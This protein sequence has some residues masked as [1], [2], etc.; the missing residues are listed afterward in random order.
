[1]KAF[2]KISV[3]IPVYNTEEHLHR[4][5][6][7][8]LGQTYSNLE[9]LL[10]NDGSTDNSGSIC[11]EYAQNDARVKVIHQ[12]NKGQS[13]ARNVGVKN[14]TG[15]YIIYVDSDDWIDLEMYTTMMDVMIANNQEIVECG[16]VHRYEDTET[17]PPNAG[18]M[19]IE[20]Q[21][22]ALKRI[23]A[24][25]AFSVCRRLCH[26][27]IITQIEFL[28]ATFAEDVYYTVET[29]SRVKSIAVM[30]YPFYN[31]YKANESTTRGAY[32][33]RSLGTVDAALFV[34]A[35]VREITSDKSFKPII[36]KFIL[37]ILM[38]NYKSMQLYPAVDPKLTHRK[39]IKKMINKYLDSGNLNFKLLLAA[40]LP[41]R[42]YNF[43]SLSNKLLMHG[44]SL[45]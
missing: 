7:S 9:I 6:D 42:F 29:I 16:E 5:I 18:E 37:T 43:L 31:Y 41:I 28:E 15:Q 3:I 40:I 45:L 34:D 22:T 38:F 2:E 14:A 13:V 35:K 8:I 21:L 4:C 33:L 24:N 10:I 39:R 11:D 12:G 20:D 26:R 17:K 30:P 36:D 44:L 23:I 1:M 27:D 25:Q 32:Q 19:V